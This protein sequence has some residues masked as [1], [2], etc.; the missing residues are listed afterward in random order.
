[1]VAS[2][3]DKYL[4][5]NGIKQS[6][7]AESCGWSKQKTSAIIRGK[8]RML[9]EEYACICDA[10]GVPYDTFYRIAAQEASNV[11]N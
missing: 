7:I 1:M 4:A 9:A 2:A 8:S 10:L 6:Y 11:Q 5:A 3:I